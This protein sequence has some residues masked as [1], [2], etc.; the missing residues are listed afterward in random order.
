MTLEGVSFAAEFRVSAD[1]RFPTTRLDF[2]LTPKHHLETSYWYN[3]YNTY[4]DTLN[5][6]DQTF[7][8]FPQVVTVSAVDDNYYD[9]YR[10]HNDEI[11]GRGVIN[12]VEPGLIRVQADEVTYDLHIM[13]RVELEQRLLADLREYR[14]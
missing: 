10:T 1:R 7:P 14:E 5:N 9:W 13:I 6:A 4:P 2:N 8:G 12:R 11:S 3:R